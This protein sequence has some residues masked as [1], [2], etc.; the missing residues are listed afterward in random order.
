[1]TLLAPHIHLKKR[2]LSASM[3]HKKK[4]VGLGLVYNGYTQVCNSPIQALKIHILISSH[5]YI[6]MKICDQPLCIM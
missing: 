6:F 5:I 3:S 2:N 1:M 4:T